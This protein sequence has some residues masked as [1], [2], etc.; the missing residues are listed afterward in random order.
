M[1]EYSHFKSRDVQFKP[2]RG[3]ITDVHGTNRYQIM[4]SNMKAE[5][6]RLIFKDFSNFVSF[7]LI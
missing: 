4:Y 3:Y 7:K 1:S 2:T 6:N 5:I